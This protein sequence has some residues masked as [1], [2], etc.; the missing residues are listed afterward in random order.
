MIKTKPY[1]LGGLIFLSAYFGNKFLAQER[2][3]DSELL[4]YVRK[5]HR[6]LLL[7]GYYKW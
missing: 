5:R 2:Y 7:Q 4:A 1:F 3:P 6:A